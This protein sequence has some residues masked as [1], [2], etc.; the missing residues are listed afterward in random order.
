M[1]LL[2]ADIFRSMIKGIK[3]VGIPVSDQARALAFYTE[4]LGFRIIT[5]QPFDDAQRWIQVGIPGA[6]SGLVLFTPE[7]H[8]DRIGSFSQVTLFA[9]DVQHTYEQLSAKGVRFTQ[10]PRE[11][12]WGTAAIF[13]DP[14]G[15]SFVLASK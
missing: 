3:F 14:D 5:D 6:V 2:H 13:E 15:N 9:D 11:A 4:T 7:G 8:E 1:R 12:D 10:R